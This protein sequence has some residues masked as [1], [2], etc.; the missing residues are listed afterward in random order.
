MKK[1][2]YVILGLMVGYMILCLTGPS[3]TVVERSVTINKPREAIKDQLL[4]LKF[5]HE[6]WSPWTEKDPNMKINFSGEP[7]KPGN[8]MA[9]ESEVKDVGKGS[10]T[11]NG[12]NGDSLLQ[13]LHFDEWGDS[14]IYLTMAAEG[15]GTKVGW[16]MISNVP[17]FG[18]GVML[19][20]KKKMDA[21][22]GGDFEKGLSKLKAELEAEPAEAV[23]SNY[24]VQEI[25]FPAKNYIGTK[26]E[27]L[28]M[29]KVGTFFGMNLGAIMDDMKKNKIELD[30]P[31][32]GLYWNFN[33]ADMSAEAVACFNAAKGSKVKG[34]ENYEF[35]AGKALQVVYFGDYMKVGP[36]HEAIQKYMT[37]KGL[38]HSAFIEEYITDPMTEKDTTKWQTNIIYVLK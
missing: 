25:D 22:L 28:T 6:K 19:F 18:R 3:K 33:N 31:P 37:E 38:T 16:G 4:D 20:M 17:F 21:M 8:S 7:G 34:W 26:K 11:F 2:L 32:T 27:K 35:P 23:A 15:E 12:I 29:D 24:E 1:V 5:F 10:M 36:A 30:G 13:T 9:W 14:K